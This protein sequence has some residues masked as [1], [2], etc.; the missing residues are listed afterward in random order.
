MWLTSFLFFQFCESGVIYSVSSCD[1]KNFGS[2]SDPFWYLEFVK[3]I[4]K[5]STIELLCKI[6]AIVSLN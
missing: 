6:K 1:F 5:W 4:F 3:N 2:G